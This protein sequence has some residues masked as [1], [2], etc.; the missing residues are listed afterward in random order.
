MNVVK[1]E[2]TYKACLITGPTHNVLGLK[3]TLN[4][5]SSIRCIKRELPGDGPCEI[6]E[7]RLALSVSEGVSIANRESPIPLF[8]EQIEYCPTDTP[9][10]EAY[11]ELAKSIVCAAFRDF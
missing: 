3:L 7:T 10:Y 9:E 1:H 2:G 11:I 4:A 6:D 5:P 8:V